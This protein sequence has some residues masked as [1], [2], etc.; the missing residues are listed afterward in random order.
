MG[1][2]P[3]EKLLSD[4]LDAINH[5]ATASNDETPFS[6][7]AT[8]EDGVLLGGLAGW[9]WGGCGGITTLWL[10]SDQRGRGLGGRLLT[11]AENEILRR[12]CDRVVVA[13]M[14]FQAPAFYLRHGYEEVGRTPDMLDGTAKHRFFKRLVAKRLVAAPAQT[15]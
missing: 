9:T 15:H 14:S 5:A 4:E 12:G 1:S 7:R 6:I 10:R 2:P 3:L 8:A 11:A 13:T